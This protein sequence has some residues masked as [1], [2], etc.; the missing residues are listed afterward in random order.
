MAIGLD[1]LA[2]SLAAVTTAAAAIVTAVI[3]AVVAIKAATGTEQQA[4]NRECYQQLTHCAPPF[5]GCSRD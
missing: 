5:P 1:Y 3:A 4:D 2:G